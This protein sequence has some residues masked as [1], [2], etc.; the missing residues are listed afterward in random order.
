M[1]DRTRKIHMLLR[2][3]YIIQQSFKFWKVLKNNN[4]ISMAEILFKDQV[5]IEALR[6]QVL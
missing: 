4:K 6:V 3:K 1:L 5:V 2:H